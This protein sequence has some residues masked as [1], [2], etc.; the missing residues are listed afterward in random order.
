MPCALR[1][2]PANGP[3]MTAKSEYLA[4]ALTPLSRGT[5]WKQYLRPT[6][7]VKTSSVLPGT[8]QAIARAETPACRSERPNAAKHAAMRAGQTL[9]RTNNIP[10]T[11][12]AQPGQIGQTASEVGVA[13]LASFGTT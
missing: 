8:N 9:I 1:N 11:K 3:R 6:A 12:I 7:A 5:P 2:D 10:A 13:N 4:R